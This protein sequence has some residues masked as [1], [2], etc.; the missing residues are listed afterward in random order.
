MPQALMTFEEVGTR[1]VGRHAGGHRQRWTLTVPMRTLLLARYDGRSE[2]IDELC[3]RFGNVPRWRVRKWAADLGLARQKE[4]P[5]SEGDARY[6]EANLYRS[7]VADIAR[8]LGRTQTAVRLKAKRL[9]LS[10][11]GE[12]YTQRQLALGLGCDDHKVRRW[13]DA[14]WLRGSRRQTERCDAQGGDMWYFSDAAVRAF[15]RDHPNEVDPRR[16]DWVWLVDVLT[17]SL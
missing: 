13:V 12:G 8:H 5:W 10:K 4:P 15:V 1:R 2:T 11:S 16:A 6:L 3:R 9:G 7:S 14:G 17:N